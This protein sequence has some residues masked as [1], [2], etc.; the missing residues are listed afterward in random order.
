MTIFSKDNI[1]R[2]LKIDRKVRRYEGFGKLFET[3]DC[4]K[5]E[6]TGQQDAANYFHENAT[7]TKDE[8]N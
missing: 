6:D 4:P 5:C 2:L 7:N 1:I 3:G 8:K